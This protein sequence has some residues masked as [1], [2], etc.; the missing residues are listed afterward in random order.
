MLDLHDLWLS[1]GEAS[2][3]TKA[4]VIAVAAAAGGSGAARHVLLARV[5][6]VEPLETLYKGGAR[7]SA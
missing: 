1:R 3:W 6:A 4:V 2:E 7:G 5:E